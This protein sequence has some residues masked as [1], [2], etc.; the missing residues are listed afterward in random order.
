[1]NIFF[2]DEAKAGLRAIAFH[3]ARDNK[4]R[5]LSFIQEL[6]EAAM[7]IGD[8]PNAY[9]LIPRYEAYGHRR[10]PYGAYLIIYT[11]KMDHIIIDAILHGAQDYEAI[12]F[13]NS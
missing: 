1:M 4:K 8:H 10:K 9:P 5:A 6:R 12:L 3:I 11:V 13:P 2:S 7:A